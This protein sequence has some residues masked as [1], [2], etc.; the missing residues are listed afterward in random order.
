[1][2]DKCTCTKTRTCKNCLMFDD[3]Y[4]DLSFMKN[5]EFEYEDEIEFE[6]EF[7]GEKDE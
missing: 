4:S 7:F 3:H 6:E 1:M 2:L 5:K